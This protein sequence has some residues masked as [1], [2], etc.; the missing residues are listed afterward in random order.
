MTA[1]DSPDRLRH[2]SAFAALCGVSPVEVSSG[3][4]KRHRLNIGGDR[5]ANAALYRIVITRL[6]HDPVTRTY[7]DRRI[8]EGKTPREVIRALKRYI[9]REIY[10]L[11]TYATP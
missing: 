9:A 5:Q 8:T 3:P 2:E 10:T 4:R 7:R 6:R 11:L 1:G